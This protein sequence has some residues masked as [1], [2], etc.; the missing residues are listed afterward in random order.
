VEFEPNYLWR[1]LP[2]TNKHEGVLGATLRFE[3]LFSEDYRQV[4]YP[5]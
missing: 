5:D 2:E 1:R 4:V 3:V